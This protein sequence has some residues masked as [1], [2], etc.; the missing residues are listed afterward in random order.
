MTELLIAGFTIYIY[1]LLYSTVPSRLLV[2]YVSSAAAMQQAYYRFN[3][4]VE[5]FCYQTPNLRYYQ[6]VMGC[7]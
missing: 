5:Y 2:T 3:Q 4:L 6:A 7:K 1:I